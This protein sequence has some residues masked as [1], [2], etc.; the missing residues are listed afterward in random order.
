VLFGWTLLGKLQFFMA[1]FLFCD[2]YLNGHVRAGSR[3]YLWDLAFVAALGAVV[4]L[5]RFQLEY[6]FLPWLWLLLFTAAFRGKVVPWL[7]GHPLLTT[8]GGMCYTI[9]MYHWLMISGLIRLTIR[10][11]THIFWLDCYFS[12]R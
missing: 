7:L 8:I 5:S 4:F 1:G 3:H 11:S 9:Y 2:L 12:L 6:Q 10:F